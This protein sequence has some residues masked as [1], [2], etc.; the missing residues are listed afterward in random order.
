[1]E[2]IDDPE[3]GAWWARLR[4][5]R[6]ALARSRA[7]LL[8]AWLIVIPLALWALTRSFGLERGY[9]GSPLIALTPYVAALS[10]LAVLSALILGRR[11]AAAVAGLAAVSLF[12]AVLPRAFS[13]DVPIGEDPTLRVMSANLLEGSADVDQLSDRIEREGVDLLSVQELTPLA[14]RRI[15]SSAIGERLRFSVT[16][17]LPDS[18]GIGLYSSF[19]LRGAPARFAGNRPTIRA[20]LKPPGA[21]RVQA[22]AIHPLPPTGPSAVRSLERYLESIPAPDPTRP[23]SILVGDFNATLDNSD[24][25]ALLDRGYE[26][27][28]DELGAGL[29]P[30]WPGDLWPPPVTIDHVLIDGRLGAIEYDVQPQDGSDHDAVLATLALPPTSRSGPGAGRQRESPA[31]ARGGDGA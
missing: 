12:A 9:P 14:A 3:H 20:S 18:S 8:L 22:F 13:A 24:F 5:R 17:S 11:G 25:R 29:T 16:D 28:A 4:E 27:V 19:P 23:P 6:Q 15:A 21:K 7:S 10:P 30:T 26:D 31:S 1:V 2:G